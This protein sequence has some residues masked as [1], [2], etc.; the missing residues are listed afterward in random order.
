MKQ[1]LSTWIFLALIGLAFALSSCSKDKDLDDYR[2]EKLQSDLAEY[3]AVEGSYSGYLVSKENKNINLGALKITLTAT[4][5]TV[6]S[7]DESRAF[8]RPVLFAEI[9]YRGVYESSIVGKNSIYEPSTG[10]FHTEIEIPIVN[11]TGKDVVETVMLEGSVGSSTLEGVM[12]VTSDSSGGGAFTLTLNNSSLQDLT[13]QRKPDV[14]SGREAI[15]KSFIGRVT[16]GGSDTIQKYDV[17]LHIN[18]PVRDKYNEIYYILRPVTETYLTVTL[19]L[20]EHVSGA[21][22]P[23]A[24]WNNASSTLRGVV[25]LPSNNV[26]LTLSCQNFNFDEKN[27]NFEC[28]FISTLI[29]T[30]IIMKFAPKSK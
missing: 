24:I 23:F 22:F 11:E 3:K 19:F 26:T 21:T 10:H 13:A 1:K 2:N 17:R 15:Q 7:N 28:N 20:N 5:Q 16:S 29:N 25:L 14:G 4:T 18:K 27:Y 12:Y 9:R 6:Q 30:P 8:A